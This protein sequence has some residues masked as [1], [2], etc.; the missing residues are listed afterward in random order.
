MCKFKR[1]DEADTNVK[2]V[3][4]TLLFYA[5]LF[6]LPFILYIAFKPSPDTTLGYVPTNLTT[7]QLYILTEVLND[8]IPQFSN[9]NDL[10][11]IGKD[12]VLVTKFLKDNIEE[13]IVYCKK[14]KMVDDCNLYNRI[15]LKAN[16]LGENY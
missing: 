5:F 12:Y 15:K 8:R 6:S 13:A 2:A 7:R 4:L 10:K 16:E 14:N 11:D 9:P 1:E 3:I